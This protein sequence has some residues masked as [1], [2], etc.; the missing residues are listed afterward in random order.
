M[1]VFVLSSRLMLLVC[2]CGAAVCVRRVVLLHMFNF[3][4][5]QANCKM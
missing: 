5:S 3:S 2:V 4:D 1:C